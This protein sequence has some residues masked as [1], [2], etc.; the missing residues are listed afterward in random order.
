VTHESDLIARWM[1]VP[2]V[3]VGLVTVDGRT[4]AE[5]VSAWLGLMHAWS[6]SVEAAVAHQDAG[7][8]MRLGEQI[9][10]RYGIGWEPPPPAE[11]TAGTGQDDGDAPLPAWA[12]MLRRVAV[13]LCEV[14]VGLSAET[15]IVAVVLLVALVL[16]VGGAR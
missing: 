3:Y 6:R 10:A 13:L 2:A 12:R 16:V 8:V 14:V 15:F 9:T 7:E 1:R 5:T 4:G 11:I